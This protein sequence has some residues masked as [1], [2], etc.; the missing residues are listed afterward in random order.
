MNSEQLLTEVRTPSGQMIKLGERYTNTFGVELEV[1]RI[2]RPAPDD[3]V[4][5]EFMPLDASL[6]QWWR[7]MFF[8]ECRLRLPGRQADTLL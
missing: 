8:S 7:G 5:V 2:S 6:A 3:E 1:K 4:L